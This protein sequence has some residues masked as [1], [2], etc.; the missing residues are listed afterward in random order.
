M[1][2]LVDQIITGIEKRASIVLSSYNP[3][4]YYYDLEKNDYKGNSKRY[5]VLPMAAENQDGVTRSVTIEQEFQIVLTDN[6]TNDAKSDT[7]L[8]EVIKSL[9]DQQDDLLNDLALTKLGVSS[10]VL[11]VVFKGFEEPEILE[12]SK[13]TALRMNISVRYRRNL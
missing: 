1:S 10:I 4:R 12:E 9:Y 11:L 5:A 8:Q 6:Y 3:L 2:N 7:D 13:T